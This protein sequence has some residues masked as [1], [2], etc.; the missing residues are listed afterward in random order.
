MV[1]HDPRQIVETLRN[2]L[3]SHDKRIVFIFGAG[4]SCA[5]NIAPK[6]KPY[7][8]LIPAVEGLTKLC[9]AAVEENNEAFK[10]AWQSLEKE[11]VAEFK[12]KISGKDE[13]LY[14]MSQS[15]LDSP[16]EPI[17]E[18]IFPV[19]NKNILEEI[20]KQYKEKGS[21]Y[22]E[23]VH[24]VIR[25]SYKGHYRKMVPMI[26]K[27]LEFR[28]NNDLHK[29]IIDGINLL[30]NHI[31]EK[32]RYF[33]FEEESEREKAL[34]K[35][36]KAKERLKAPI[37][38]ASNN[39]TLLSGERLKSEGIRPGRLMGDL[40]KE[41]EKIAIAQETEDLEQVMIQL[42]KTPL[43]QEAENL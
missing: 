41:A 32:N 37:L 26:F 39:Q 27:R 23:K 25:N 6:D 33:T 42:K 16:T 12:K 28:S 4:T 10:P 22:H 18:V 2:H 5:V 36:I 24:Y 7:K 35:Y 17:E 30:K 19:V 3:A 1:T 40:I 20:V 29:P 11:L 13:I 15:S 21:T 34:E 9:K 38:R 14:K 43:W 31:D 8:P